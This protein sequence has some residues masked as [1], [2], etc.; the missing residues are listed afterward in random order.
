MP[1]GLTTRRALNFAVNTTMA[2]LVVQISGLP[3]KN[4]PD[5]V[6][7]NLIESTTCSLAAS[8]AGGAT[9]PKPPANCFQILQSAIAPRRHGCTARGGATVAVA[10]AAAGHGAARAGRDVH[11]AR[12]QGDADL[13]ADGRRRAHG[14]CAGRHDRR[15]GRLWYVYHAGERDRKN[16]IQTQYHNFSFSYNW[17][18]LF[19]RL[20]LHVNTCLA[21]QV[22]A[23]T[24]R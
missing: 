10:A 20:I 18:S 16:I 6:S 8:A 13:D 24:T 3:Q 21:H 7:K 11:V 1:F 19:S 12:R 22:S 4:G 15:L 17:H 2:D 5:S 14:L 9:G 23:W